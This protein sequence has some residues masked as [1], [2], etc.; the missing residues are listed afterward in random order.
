MTIDKLTIFVP[1][2]IGG[3]LSKAITDCANNMHPVEKV[4][5]LR[6]VAETC[7]Q[8]A[9]KQEAHNEQHGVPERIEDER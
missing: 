8:E 6:T 3:E 9:D 4:R 1:T 2:D 5:V 7:T